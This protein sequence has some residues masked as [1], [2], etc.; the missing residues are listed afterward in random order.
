MT[1]HAFEPHEDQPGYCDICGNTYE[2]HNDQGVLTFGLPPLAEP[3][4]LEREQVRL[5]GQRVQR[6]AWPVT[7]VVLEEGTVWARFGPT[8]DGRTWRWVARDCML[9]R[10]PTPKPHGTAGVSIR[11]A[12]L[13]ANF[14]QKAGAAPGEPGWVISPLGQ[15]GINILP[16]ATYARTETEAKMLMNVYLTVGGDGEKFWYLLRAIQYG[17]K[18]REEEKER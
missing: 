3:G 13:E 10:W 4:E 15:P 9:K 2:W 5:T 16:G 11:Y 6:C 7:S 17:I 1:E 18:S 12:T 8:P 14:V